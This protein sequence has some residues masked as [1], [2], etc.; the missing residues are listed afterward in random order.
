MKETTKKTYQLFFG[1]N[2][3]DGYVTNDAWE[4]FREVLG[5]SF[6]GYSVQDVQGAWKGS[7]EDSKLVTVTTKYPE[8]VQDICQAYIDTFKQDA[9][10]M[11]VSNPMSYITKECEVF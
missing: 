1:R 9:V 3:P 10:G 4:G 5:L 7:Q 8:K 11:L 2:T 6:A